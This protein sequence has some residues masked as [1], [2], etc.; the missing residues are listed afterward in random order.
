LGFAFEVIKPFLDQPEKF[1]PIHLQVMRHHHRLINFRREQLVFDLLGEQPLPGIVSMMPWFSSS[2][3]A[4]AT[5]FRFNRNS[6]ASGR[7]DGSGS[8][9]FKPP[10]AAA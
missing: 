10:E 1:F 6:S 9:G 7:M 4:L 8:P 5:V 2:E 3:Y